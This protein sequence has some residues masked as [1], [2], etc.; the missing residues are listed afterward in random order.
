MSVLVTGGLGYI[1]S[2]VSKLLQ[3]RGES[4]V[5]VDDLTAG[6]GHRLGSARLV[7]LDL[8]AP[9][10]VEELKAA[11][12]AFHVTK[13]IHFAARKKVGESVDLPEWYYQQN[14][15][16]MAN[17]LTAMREAQVHRLVFSSSA[18]TYGMPDVEAVAE[19]ILCEPINPYGETKLIGEWMVANAERAWGLRGANLRYF[20]VAG[21]GWPEL[22][23][24]AVANLIPIIF[25]ALASGQPPKVFGDSYPTPDGTCIRDYVHVLDLAEA[26]LV[27]LDYLDQEVREHNTF[28]VGTGVGS[29]VYE[30]IN[31]VKKV[32]GVDFAVDVVDARA[33]D[34]PKLC[35]NVT[36]INQTLGWRA[37]RDL[38]EIVQSAWDA[39]Q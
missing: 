35:A 14:I 33:G 21:A 5:V 25:A 7:E 4:V 24:T 23:D 27:A 28:N 37:E 19:D 1:G 30:V 18:A 17:L 34:P 32:T 39:I 36:R 2:H 26:H 13:V 20:N 10:A 11:F 22:A 38:H 31:E 12:K 29:S 8:A 15:G 9:N 6:Y 3:E 16:G